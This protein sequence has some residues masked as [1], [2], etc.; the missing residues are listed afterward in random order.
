MGRGASGSVRVWERRKCYFSLI[1]SYP[2]TLPTTLIPYYPTT[3]QLYYPT[4]YPHTLLPYYPSSNSG[5]LTYGGE[6]R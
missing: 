3:L 1:P 2:T 4:Y 5:F 6:R